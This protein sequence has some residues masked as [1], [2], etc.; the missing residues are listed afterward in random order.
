MEAATAGVAAKAWA[1]SVSKSTTAR[2]SVAHLRQGP[3]FSAHFGELSLL[4][5]RTSGLGCR[6]MRWLRVVFVGAAALGLAGLHGC[7]G[8][9]VIDAEGAGGDG[10][11]DGSSSSG[12]GSGGSSNTSTG[13][14]SSSCMEG[15]CT[16]TPDGSCDCSGSCNGKNVKATCFATGGAS[17]SC[18]CTV[19]GSPVGKCEA[20]A[21]SFA[22]DVKA[23]CCNEFF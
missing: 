19:S 22:C 17:F 4:P 3:S 9:V 20:P 13:S 23:G 12:S 5:G 11:N 7:G 21:G 14:G 16:G 2:L 6:V 18:A 1:M 15:T 8:K 10:G